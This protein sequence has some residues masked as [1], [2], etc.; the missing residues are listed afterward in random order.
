MA[1]LLSRDYRPAQLSPIIF[2]VRT[3]MV[4]PDFGAGC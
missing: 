4:C 2:I 1:D 3:F